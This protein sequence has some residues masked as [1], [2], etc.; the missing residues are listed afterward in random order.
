MIYPILIS[1]VKCTAQPKISTAIVQ[2]LKPNLSYC[3]N[4]AM[5]WVTQT[6]MRKIIG[7]R[8]I[9]IRNHAAVLCGN[10]VIMPRTVPMV[11]SVTAVI[12]AKLR[13]TVISVWTV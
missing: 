1:I 4:T 12:S 10:G 3:V 6:A 5:Q 2:P 8:F 11:N 7:K 13:T 9:A